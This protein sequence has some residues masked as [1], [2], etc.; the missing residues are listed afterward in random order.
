MAN[1]D[2]RL[3]RLESALAPKGRAVFIWND[4][5]PGTV[6]REKAR[7]IEIGSLSPQDRIVAIGWQQ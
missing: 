7:L 4:Y 2:R 3:D 6:E 5:E 1:L